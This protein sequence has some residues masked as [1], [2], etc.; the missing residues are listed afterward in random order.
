[1][2]KKKAR[3]DHEKYRKLCAL[4]LAESLDQ[5]ERLRLK[6]HLSTCA[7]CRDLYDQYAEISNV[8][9]AFLGS[10]VRVKDNER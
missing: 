7:S 4:A 1:M 2:E 6:Q 9:M 10:R 5:E 3:D 8:G